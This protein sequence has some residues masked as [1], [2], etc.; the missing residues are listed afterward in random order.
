MVL[1]PAFMMVTVSTPRDPSTVSARMAGRERYVTMVSI[2]LILDQ[3]TSKTSQIFP[4]PKNNLFDAFCKTLF[5]G[6]TNILPV[7][8]YRPACFA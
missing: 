5:T 2:L 7:M 3:R 4:G 1:T 8:I 6:L